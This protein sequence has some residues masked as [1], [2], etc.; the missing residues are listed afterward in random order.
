MCFHSVGSVSLESWLEEQLW[1][2]RGMKWAAWI[3]HVLP[4]P[5]GQ[6]LPNGH[7]EL[8]HIINT[9]PNILISFLQVL[10]LQ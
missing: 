9:D 7:L 10:P 2:R 3:S 4:S 6:A 5:H 1:V 8:C